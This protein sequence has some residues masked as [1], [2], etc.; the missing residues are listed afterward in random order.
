MVLASASSLLGEHMRPWLER[1][2]DVLDEP[3][4]DLLLH[5]FFTPDYEMRMRRIPSALSHD[6]HS[7]TVPVTP[8]YAATGSDIYLAIMEL[9]FYENGILKLLCTLT[10]QYPRIL[11]SKW[12]CIFENSFT[13]GCGCHRLVWQHDGKIYMM[14]PV[15]TY[16]TIRA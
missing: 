15:I 5:R 12:I 2:Q 13:R 1:V 3:F 4:C 11:P 8:L 14:S 16:E 10:L 7:S 6:F 9:F